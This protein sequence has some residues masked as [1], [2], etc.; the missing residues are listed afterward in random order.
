MADTTAVIVK[1]AEAEGQ[2]LSNLYTY[3]NYALGIDSLES[4]YGPNVLLLKE[5]AARYDPG[6][7]MTRTG[8]FIFQK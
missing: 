2:N 6:K 3:P 8:G 5:V 7:V 1:A 4:L